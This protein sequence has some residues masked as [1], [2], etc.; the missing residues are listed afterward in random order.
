[1]ARPE[2][3]TPIDNHLADVQAFIRATTQR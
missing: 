3:F 2:H 1:L